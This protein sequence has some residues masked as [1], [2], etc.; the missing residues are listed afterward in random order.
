[1]PP[2]KGGKKKTKV[3]VVDST[4]IVAAA[5]L[6]DSLA[7]AAADSAAKAVEAA[8]GA[9]RDGVYYGWGTSRHG[10]IQAVVE[11]RNGH[12]FSAGISQCLTRYTCAWIAHLPG[13]VVTRQSAEAD[14]VSGATQSSD[15]FY[16]AVTEALKLAK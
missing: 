11:I 4:A 14:V 2:A 9:Y 12:I 10:D 8:R 7:K 5:H 13:Q 16:W 15:A 6:A 3:A 1:M